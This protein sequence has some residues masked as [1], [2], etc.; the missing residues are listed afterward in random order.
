MLKVVLTRSIINHSGPAS[1]SNA[2]SLYVATFQ[3]ATHTDM[4]DRSINAS[5]MRWRH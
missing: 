2:H 1:R 4:T 5:L 3:N